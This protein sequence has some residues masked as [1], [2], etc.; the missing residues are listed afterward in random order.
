ME[1]FTPGQIVHLGSGKTATVVEDIGGDVVDLQLADGSFMME[2]RREL[3]SVVTTEAVHAKVFSAAFAAAFLVGTATGAGEMRS[4]RL[5]SA[6]T[7]AA[8]SAGNAAYND[9]GVNLGCMNAV[10]RDAAN[11]AFQAA[12]EHRRA[13]AVV[14]R[15]TLRSYAASEHIIRNI[16]GIGGLDE[17]GYLTHL[18]TWYCMVASYALSE[19]CEVVERGASSPLSETEACDLI[20][21]GRA[22]EVVS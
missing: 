4:D 11:K 16:D 2:V 13:G 3:S 17:A 18:R 7:A 9:V 14:S 22:V 20:R 19:G 5:L 12:G 8:F 15:Q 10:I 1:Y 21:A 6:V